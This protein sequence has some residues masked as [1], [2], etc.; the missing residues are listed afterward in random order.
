VVDLI[1][2]GSIAKSRPAGERLAA[3]HVFQDI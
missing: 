3:V 2:T 1:S